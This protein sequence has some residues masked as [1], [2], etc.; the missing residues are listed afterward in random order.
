MFYPRLKGD[1]IPLT[2]RKNPLCGKS[3]RSPCF[4][5]ASVISLRMHLFIPDDSKNKEIVPLLN[6]ETF[7]KRIASLRHQSKL[8]QHEV[9]ERCC[10][11]VQAVSKWERGQSCPDILILD[12]LA[13]ALGVEVKDL[14]STEDAV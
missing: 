4:S 12:D 6:M 1:P 2:K 14:F 3:T 5:G 11:S 7:G 13:A 8:K 10:V 9:A